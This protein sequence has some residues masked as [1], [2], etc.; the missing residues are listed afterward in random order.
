MRI[1]IEGAE[2]KDFDFELSLSKWRKAKDRA[3]FF[4]T[5]SQGHP[6]PSAME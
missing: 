6:L 4:K 2:M 5:V 1:M 3:I